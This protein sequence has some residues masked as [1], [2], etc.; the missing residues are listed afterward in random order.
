[1]PVSLASEGAWSARLE[2]FA[3]G[4]VARESARRSIAA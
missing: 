1:M 3:A 4:L 2:R